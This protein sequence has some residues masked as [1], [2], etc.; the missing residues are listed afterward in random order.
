MPGTA[1]RRSS[2]ALRATALLLPLAVACSGEA[3]GE[4]NGL[5][6]ERNESDTE[7]HATVPRVVSSSQPDD[8]LYFGESEAEQA[9]ARAH[10]R[11][12]FGGDVF[13]EGTAELEATVTKGI[14]TGACIEYTIPPFSGPGGVELFFNTL[15]E[16]GL[17]PRDVCG[18]R[19]IGESR[20]FMIQNF[21][22]ISRPGAGTID[23]GVLGATLEE[24]A[25]L[26]VSI[27]VAEER[28]G[29]STRIL[30]SSEDLEAIIVQ[31]PEG[32]FCSSYKRGFAIFE[33]DQF[34]GKDLVVAVQAALRNDGAAAGF[35]TVINDRVHVIR[36]SD[37]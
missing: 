14:N 8:I 37:L 6:D 20:R 15:P 24:C 30:S 25:D 19:T 1:L 23:V 16:G 4:G 32:S 12:T 28:P 17:T 35:T 29:R 36:A 34:E 26:S 22:S 31:G 3:Y 18:P 7:L 10:I 13:P 33:P 11:K 9:R 2:W 5:L 21:S 27:A